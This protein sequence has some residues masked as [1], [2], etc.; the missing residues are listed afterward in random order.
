MNS[1][2]FEQ[3]DD[4]LHDRMSAEERAIFESS[5]AND[6][7]LAREWELY[8]NVESSMRRAQQQH[9]DEAALKT[10]LTH[11]SEDFILHKQRAKMRWISPRALRWAAAA[12]VPLAA[13]GIYLFV[14]TRQPI[15]QR[16][17]ETYVSKNLTILSQTMGAAKDSLQA[18]IAAYNDRDYATASRIF[19]RLAET[20]PSNSEALK[21][22]GLAFLQTGDYTNALV[23]FDSLVARKDLY[24]NPGLFLKAVT[25][26]RRDAKGDLQQAHLLLEQVV[27]EKAEGYQEA[28]EWLKK[29]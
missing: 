8:R 4:Y 28:G 7:Q 14:E 29:W 26:L 10:S 15:P 11:L 1:S 22:S 18:G 2:F 16:M 6:R 27:R 9:D 17:A 3:A 12:V 21:Y 19:G 23:R 5:L 20:M 13:A 24:S 25:L